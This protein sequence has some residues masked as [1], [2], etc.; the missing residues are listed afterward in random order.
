M[1]LL[2]RIEKLCISGFLSMSGVLL[3][4]G[5]GSS[6]VWLAL[7]TQTCDVGGLGFAFQNGSFLSQHFTV[8]SLNSSNYSTMIIT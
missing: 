4:T 1:D 8:Y 6:E 7:R 2:L 3:I 5:P